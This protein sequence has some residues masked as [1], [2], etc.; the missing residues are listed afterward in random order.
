[1]K[2]NTLFLILPILLLQSCSTIMM[3]MYGMKNPEVEN[4]QS[5][6]K[7]ALKYGLDTT[8]IVTVYSPDI[9]AKLSGRGIPNA[10][11]YDRNGKY[12][13][14]RQTDTSCNA[15]LFQFIPELDPANSYH[16]PDSA[17]LNVELAKFRNMKGGVLSE[18]E[19]ADF[20]V[21]IN[22]AVWTG[23]LNK[24]H[25]KIWEDLAKNNK[26]AKV[27][28]IKVNLDMQEYWGVANSE[29]VVVRINNKK[30]TGK[31]KKNV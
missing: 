21:L 15:G 1:M 14:Y 11:I 30:K 17:N 13:E 25:V 23:K 7:R 9:A 4:E 18:V 16:M 31:T 3:K 28:V 29:K 10:S 19:K 6:K 20:Y 22:W 5:I 8:N 26:H 24:D 2:K 27:K 12:I